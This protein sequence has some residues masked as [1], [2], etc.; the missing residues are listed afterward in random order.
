MSRLKELFF[1]ANSSFIERYLS[2]F[3]DQVNERT[4]CGSLAQ[5]LNSVIQ[6]SEFS[7]YYTDTEY[8]RY[9]GKV[10]ILNI[11]DYHGLD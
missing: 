7:N 10:K 9:S 6:K 1:D 11:R 4:L 8:N 2:L 5:H 3:I